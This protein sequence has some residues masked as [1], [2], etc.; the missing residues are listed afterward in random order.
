MIEI[1]PWGV[2]ELE[3]EVEEWLVFLAD[4][5]FGQAYFAIELLQS[6]GPTLGEPYTR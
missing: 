6:R 5:S 2:V 3:P 1:I 4:R